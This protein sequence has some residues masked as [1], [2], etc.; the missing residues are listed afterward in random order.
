VT[1]AETHALLDALLSALE[2]KIAAA[3]RRFQQRLRDGTI[4]ERETVELSNDEIDMWEALQA[5]AEGRLLAGA[6]YGR[7][8]VAL[9]RQKQGRRLVLAFDLAVGKSHASAEE[10]D[11]RIAAA[12]EKF[13]T[14]GLPPT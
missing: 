10:T 3:Q 8:R 1:D 14:A 6:E 4:G 9:K 12:V 2:A 13:G 7:A 11:A 5:L